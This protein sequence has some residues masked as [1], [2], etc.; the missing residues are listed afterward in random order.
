[1][2]NSLS[3]MFSLD[4][5]LMANY[6]HKIEHYICVRNKH[7]IMRVRVRVR[8]D[9]AYCIALRLQF[10]S[11]IYV[12]SYVLCNLYIRFKRWYLYFSLLFFSFLFLKMGFTFR[13]QRKEQQ[14]EHLWL[15]HV[16][17]KEWS[18][19]LDKSSHTFIILLWEAV[20]HPSLFKTSYFPFLLLEDL[21]K[22]R[23]LKSRNFA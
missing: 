4:P 2:L 18:S 22:I 3:F 1:M 12:H 7:R 10:F 21:K 11:L 8:S 16:V 15:R 9:R 14:N 17:L 23:F 13:M 20:S 19:V 6:F 5:N